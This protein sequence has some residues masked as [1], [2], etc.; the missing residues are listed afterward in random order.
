[1]TMGA[2]HS[3]TASA[4]GRNTW[5]CGRGRASRPSPLMA[6]RV[7]PDATDIG[8][9]RMGDQSERNRLG[10]A[11]PWRD[12]GCRTGAPQIAPRWDSKSATRGAA[13]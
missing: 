3:E 6:Y 7:T 12:T 9:A 10:S 13:N 8:L 2:T 5:G 11:M 4:R 1:M